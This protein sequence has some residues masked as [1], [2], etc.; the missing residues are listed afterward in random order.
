[1]KQKYNKI[2]RTTRDSSEIHRCF[3]PVQFIFVHLRQ[4][5]RQPYPRS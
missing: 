5:S 2:F 3:T 4:V 1:M